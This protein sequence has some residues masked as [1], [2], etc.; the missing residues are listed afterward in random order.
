[1][2]LIRF[3]VLALLLTLLPEQAMAAVSAQ[4]VSATIEVPNDIRSI[5]INGETVALVGDGIHLISR[6]ATSFDGAVTIESK[7]RL[8]TK[9]IPSP[10]GFIAVG[11]AESSVATSSE[12]P[13]NLINPDSIPVDTQVVQSLGMTKLVITEFTTEAAVIKESLFDLVRPMVP[14]SVLLA[15]ERISVVGSI[16]SDKG[17]QGFIANISRD[18]G[19]LSLHTFGNSD[20]NINALATS[21]ILYG[22]SSEQL[23]GSNRRGVRDGVIF[24][25]DN[26]AKLTRVVR[27]FQASASRD[28]SSVNSSHLAAGNVLIG[29]K[30]EVAV[31]KFTSKGEPSWFLRIPGSD[32]HLSGSVLALMTNRKVDGITNF[33]PR[34]STA[35]FITLDTKKKGAFRSA[36]AISARSIKNI[37]PGL[38]L[39]VDRSGRSQLVPFTP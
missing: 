31:T 19:A 13:E 8:F 30:R 21:R 6:G 17:I 10:E 26:N 36:S 20:T 28:W 4:R 33:T 9:V 22:S 27:S 18:D 3:T 38:A 34:T 7:A 16:S 5:A 11:I 32:P 2:K 24:Y 25:L 14:S 1:M 37:A 35:L 39:I 23:A 29:S 12:L 15:S